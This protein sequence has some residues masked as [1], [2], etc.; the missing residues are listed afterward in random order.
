MVRVDKSRARFVSQHFVFE[1]GRD[2]F[3][4]ARAPESD[5][6]DPAAEVAHDD[7]NVCISVDVVAHI[8]DVH[9][10]HVSRMISPEFYARRM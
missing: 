7:E 3:D 10:E 5:E 6:S 1:D 9:S 4:G 2:F 8:V